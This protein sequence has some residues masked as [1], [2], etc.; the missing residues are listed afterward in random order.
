MANI[1]NLFE[2][3]GEG[4]NTE[5]PT[6]VNFDDFTDI[7][8][9]DNPFA[10]V[11]EPAEEKAATESDKE[12][13]AATEESAKEVPAPIEEKAEEPVEKRADIKV[14]ETKSEPNAKE[15]KKTDKPD[16]APSD[17]PFEA[18]MN[19]IE[20]KQAEETK[21]GLLHQNPI[22]AFA[23]AKDEIKDSSIT[24]DALRKEKMED[25]PELEDG[26]RVSWKM[27]YAG[28]TM[29]VSNP[30]KTTIAEQKKLIED[31]K[32]FLNA[33][34]KSKTDMT[35]K[36]TPT[37]TAQKKGRIPDY[38]G[39][40]TDMKTA[41]QSDKA[42]SYIPAEDGDIYEV[43]KNPIGIFTARAEKVRGLSH[44]KAGFTPALPLFPFSELCKIVAFFKRY[45][46]IKGGLE[47]LVDVYW[48]P[49]TEEYV[50]V[51]PPQR[52]G[53]G[54]IEAV[55]NDEY[56]D[57]VH[58]MDIHSHNNMEAHFSGVDD[59]DEK[60]TRIYVV[61]GRMD[62]YFPDITARISVGGKFVEISPDEIFE[63]P[64]SKFPIDW[65]GDLIEA[66]NAGS[67]IGIKTGG[68][69]DEV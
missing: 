63:Y 16:A 17:N 36:V 41:A 18:E 22:F 57:M 34:K 15:D 5:L 46:D 31:S 67:Y 55:L 49:K 2:L 4:Q 66:E 28:I 30:E 45:A 64:F 35:C 65:E 59:K 58:V 29:N 27:T 60:A 43:R 1:E 47:V 69:S 56:A 38:I 26:K 24:F 40:F 32:D 62:K 51:I 61:I 3:F 21:A 42:I 12:A 7:N 14:V 44:I 11:P 19:R 20:E 10:D 53:K 48:N 50:T 6:E 52:V 54:S 13:A 39:F 9:G 33:L 68:D 25:F 37:V 23:S 8:D